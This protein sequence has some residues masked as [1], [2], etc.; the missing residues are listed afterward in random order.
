MFYICGAVYDH[1]NA[2]SSQSYL[3]AW[4]KS[5]VTRFDFR[6]FG[7]RFFWRLLAWKLKEKPIFLGHFNP[8]S[9]LCINFEKNGLCYVHFGRFF[10]QPHL[11]FQQPQIQVNFFCNANLFSENWQKS[12]KVVIIDHWFIRHGGHLLHALNSYKHDITFLRTQILVPKTLFIYFYNVTIFT[13]YN[14]TIFTM[15]HFTTFYNI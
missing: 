9:K 15:Y 3:T 14:F 5:S 13:M 2:L 4:I 8:R 7:A 11:V 1:S 12:H 6:L 10:G